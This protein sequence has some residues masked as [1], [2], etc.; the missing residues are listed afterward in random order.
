MKA[1]TRSPVLQAAR[2]LTLTARGSGGLGSVHTVPPVD[3]RGGVRLRVSKAS[4]SIMKW[5][6][7]IQRVYRSGAPSVQSDGLSEHPQNKYK[8]S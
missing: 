4:L 2:C 6:V 7:P 8:S 5:E 1:S 3:T